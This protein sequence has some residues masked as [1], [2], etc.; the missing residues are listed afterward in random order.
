MIIADNTFDTTL[1][2]MEIDPAALRYA[3]ERVSLSREELAKRMST[4]IGK[5]R[6]II[7]SPEDIQ[8]WESGARGMTSVETLAAT[9]V[10]M[11]PFYALFDKERPSEPLTDFRTPPSGER[12]TIDYNTHQQFHRFNNFY[13][14][15]KDL[16]Q[17]M[18]ETENTNLPI[19]NKEPAIEVANSLRNS[20]AVDHHT[21][22]SWKDEDVALDEWKK[23]ISQL[24]IFIFSLPL[25][26][27]QVRGAS[28]WDPGAPPAILISTGDLPSARAFTLM[29]ELAHLAHRNVQGSICDPSENTR[30]TQEYRMNRIA[31]EILVPEYWIKQETINHPDSQ[32]F[33]EWTNAERNR[34]TS[35][36]KVSNQMMGIRLK[37]LG[38]VQDDGY[39]T[40]AWGTGRFFFKKGAKRKKPSPKKHER[41]RSYLGE[42][43]IS[44]LRRA[45][46]QDKIT[47]GEVVKTYLD[48]K[49]HTVDEVIAE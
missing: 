16:S 30:H 21:Q 15:V 10:C 12:S 26:I 32:V 22:H 45:L 9:E 3:R 29:H 38:I 47:I 41:Y 8:Q 46:Q 6:D 5:Y 1:G 13:E 17:R 14:M 40:S 39:S 25:N 35:I 2:V 19:A 42:R 20:L 48:V 23:R 31:A 27:Q 24:G 49:T 43:A 37:E 36:F 44:L 28:R 4:Y 33:K 11:F 7:I 18:G 34:L